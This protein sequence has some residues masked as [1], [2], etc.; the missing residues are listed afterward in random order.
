MP[1][2]LQPT[3]SGGELDPGL[4]G[5]VD[6]VRYATSL[7]T[8]RRMIVKPTGGAEKCPGTFFR[9]KAKDPTKPT[10]L[11][12]FIYSTGV[13]Y[14]VEM[15][16]QYLRFWVNGAPLE[17]SPGVPL[18]V[19]TPYVGAEIYQVRFTQSADVLFLVHPSYWQ[20]ELR[21]V[22]ATSFELRDFGFRRGPFR[23]FNTN[24]AAI[25]AVSGT[26][27]VVT[28]T[29]N[30]DTFTAS[31][32]GSLLYVEEKELRSVKPWVPAEKNVPLGALR[33]SD[34]KVYRAVS[35]P[36]VTSPAYYVAGGVRPIHES[37][38][39]FDGPQDV[40]ND[41]VNA[42]TVGVEWEY[43]H[44]GFGILQITGYTDA[45]TVTAVVIE[46]IPDSVVGTAPSPAGSWTFSGDGTTKAFTIT[47]AVSDSNYNY[48]VEIGG[49]PV[50]S[51]PYYEGGGGVGGGGGG[52]ITRPGFES[53]TETLI[54]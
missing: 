9:G 25:M 1:K 32:V 7:K 48:S 19:A 34:S 8:C 33:R 49:V 41:G 13:K 52:G 11:I 16:D 38:R 44:G 20:K 50:Q 18:E 35:V 40:R 2:F 42:Y 12:P 21:R 23:P 10:R 36:A 24:E 30:V 17:S 27:G 37:G 31:M 5:R 4:H 3:L 46:R 39:A 54:V 43:V 15:G 53:N 28:V 29:T 22:T 51:N 6:L 47:G 14:L 26:Q 45:R